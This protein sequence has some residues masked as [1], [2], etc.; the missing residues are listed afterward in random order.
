M[1]ACAF[2]TSASLQEGD[3][4]E[5]NAQGEKTQVPV[6]PPRRGP[7]YFVCGKV[8][9]REAAASEQRHGAQ[10]PLLTGAGSPCRPEQ[11]TPAPPAP[12][13]PPRSSLWT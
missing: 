7:R 8:M 6:R 11:V 2:H 5:E 12:G 9:E 1:A 4:Q 10:G 3:L 13:L